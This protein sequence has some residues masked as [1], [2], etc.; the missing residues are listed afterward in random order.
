MKIF[1]FHKSD[2]FAGRPASPGRPLRW[3]TGFAWQ[4]DLAG[5]VTFF[6]GGF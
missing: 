6:G 3:Q 2:R 5:C 1:D 4:N